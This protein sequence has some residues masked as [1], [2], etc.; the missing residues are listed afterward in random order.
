VCV[1][2]CVCVCV[3]VCVCQCQSKRGCSNTDPW[4]VAVSEK[5]VEHGML[6]AKSKKEL[7]LTLLCGGCSSGL[8]S[9]LWQADGLRGGISILR[10]AK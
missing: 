3:S 8:V 10:V 9:D 5:H 7:L 4:S 2:V 6:P 1:C